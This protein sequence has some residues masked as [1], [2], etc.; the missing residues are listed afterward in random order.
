MAPCSTRRE[1]IFQDHSM[2]PSPRA[3][4]ILDAMLMVAA[5]AVWLALSRLWAHE[6]AS[7]LPSF[8]RAVIM[9][10]ALRTHVA[11]YALSALV[12]STLAVLA[13]KLRRPRPR[14]WVVA[15]QPGAVACGVAAVMLALE[16]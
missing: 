2:R 11:G 8:A 3:P 12:P 16:V 1:E 13:M 9:P 4:S 6:L 15:R 7:E 10:I 14:L 5:A